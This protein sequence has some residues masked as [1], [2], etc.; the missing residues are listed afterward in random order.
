MFGFK[1]I[2]VEGVEADDVIGIAAT[3]FQ[4]E[5]YDV[6]VYSNDKD[7]YQLIGDGIKVIRK[8]NSKTI[9][10]KPSLIK[11]E[12][13]V[14]PEMWTQFRA[15]MGDPSDNIKPLAGVGPK[16][17]VKMLEAGI[18]PAL[19]NFSSL[20]KKTRIKYKQLRA[21]WYKVHVAYQLSEI[22]RRADFKLFSNIQKELLQAKIGRIKEAPRRARVSYG[23]ELLT[24]FIEVCQEY[25]FE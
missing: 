11:E 13:G 14:D 19:K 8:V 22:S 17:A 18:D 1:K 23:D 2:S 20:P 15:L 16:T 10:V 7:F 12:Y 9:E 3:S 6:Y 4:E 21:S 24:N 25:E 5:G